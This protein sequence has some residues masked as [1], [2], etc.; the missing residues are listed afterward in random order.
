MDILRCSAKSFANA[1]VPRD[2]LPKSYLKVLDEGAHRTIRL[3]SATI[4]E[5][6][7][8]RATCCDSLKGSL[9]RCPL[10]AQASERLS[11]KAFLCFFSISRARSASRAPRKAPSAELSTQLTELNDHPRKWHADSGAVPNSFIN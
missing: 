10:S 5:N 3:V 11:V 2:R 1:P 6:G 8:P 4:G 9:L 7:P